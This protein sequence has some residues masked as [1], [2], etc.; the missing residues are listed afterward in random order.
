MPKLPGALVVNAGDLL[1]RWTNGRWKAA[2]HRV[3]CPI[4]PQT[5]PEPGLVPETKEADSATE[6]T[7]AIAP[8]NN[9][10]SQESVPGSNASTTPERC[11]ESASTENPTDEISEPEPSL[12]VGVA[13]DAELS[14]QS[15]TAAS[16]LSLLSAPSSSSRVSTV[17]TP[18][19]ACAGAVSGVDYDALILA[20]KTD[21][22]RASYRKMKAKAEARG[23]RK[24]IEEL[25]TI[26]NPAKLPEI[27]GLIEKY[28]AG[29]LL[30]MAQCKYQETS[31][32]VV[33]EQLGAASAG[34][35]IQ[36]ESNKRISLVFFTRP[37]EGTLVECLPGC[38]LAKVDGIGARLFP[39]IWAQ[40]YRRVAEEKRTAL[41]AGDDDN[42][43]NNEAA[44]PSAPRAISHSS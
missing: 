39:P 22:Q 27:P 29:S 6:T 26:H 43:G 33:P 16:M 13:S 9:V 36:Q 19:T 38:E 10:S 44:S 18:P 37:C 4:E 35:E 2:L 24:Q 20:A 11:S 34:K 8:V 31:S 42:T 17:D 21:A 1:H 28:G 32:A 41:D 5:E 14:A 23:I 7:A 15:S 30:A 25:Y 12:P 3:A 40:D